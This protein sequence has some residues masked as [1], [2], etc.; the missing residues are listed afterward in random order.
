[1]TKCEK[2]YKNAAQEIQNEN[3][4]SIWEFPEKKKR[5]K[6]VCLD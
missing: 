6:Y 3:S 2:N 1:M 5:V 4:K